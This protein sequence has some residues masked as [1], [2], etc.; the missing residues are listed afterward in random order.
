MARIWRWFGEF[1][2]HLLNLSFDQKSTETPS[3]TSFMQ[4]EVVHAEKKIFFIFEVVSIYYRGV[5]EQIYSAWHDSFLGYI[6][7]MWLFCNVP[8]RL[9]SR[10]GCKKRVFPTFRTGESIWV[11]WGQDLDDPRNSIWVHRLFS[12]GSVPPC[13]ILSRRRNDK[14]WGLSQKG[15]F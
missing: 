1:F 5:R 8:L 9:F 6:C 4:F 12:P 2:A 13:D 10:N 15:R 14:L 3:K 7:R 11:S